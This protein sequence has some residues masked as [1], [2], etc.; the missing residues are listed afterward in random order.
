MAGNGL[1]QQQR[2]WLDH[3]KGCTSSGLSMRDYADRHGFDVQQFYSWKSQLK[4]L[5]VLPEQATA[6]AAKQRSE[7]SF[8]RAS[9]CGRGLAAGP[10]QSSDLQSRSCAVRINL[11]NGIMIEVPAGFAPDALGA[12]IGAAM[13]LDA[14]KEAPL[15]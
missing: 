12:L 6:R 1:T 13:R 9:V 5:G 11:A 14:D 3:V 15:S 7:P 8:I 2:F 10:L 4:T